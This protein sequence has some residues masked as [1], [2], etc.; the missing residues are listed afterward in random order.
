MKKLAP[1]ILKCAIATAIGGI[2]TYCVITN[3]E[4]GAAATDAERY[5]ILAD[6]F[7]IPGI[8]LILLGVL[9][10]LSNEGAMDGVSFL[11]SGL[12]K[13]LMPIGRWREERYE[14]YGDYIER[15][16]ANRATGY[17]FIFAVGGAFT[18]VAIVFVILFYQVY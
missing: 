9:V 11:M 7:A 14:K 4:Y 10:F 15:K 13:R 12:L 18:A 5:K 1:I 17:G 16:R 3:Y 2:M 8:I 6:A